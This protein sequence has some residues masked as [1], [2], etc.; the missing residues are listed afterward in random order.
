MKTA[1]KVLHDKAME[2]VDKARF[3]KISG[4]EKDIQNYF[5]EAFQLEK[6]AALSV[7]EGEKFNLIKSLYTRSAAYLA[8]EIGDTQ[9]ALFLGN[10]G[11]KSDPPVFIKMEIQSLLD[12]IST[13][14]HGQNPDAH[15]SS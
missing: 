9:E 6:E 4:D 14:N 8:F 5:Y 10:L 2:L 13:T 1:Y 3:A 15:S 12:K 7:P 11:L